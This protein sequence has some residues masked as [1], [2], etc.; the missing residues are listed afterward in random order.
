MGLC[1][2][3]VPYPQCRG[4]YYQVKQF[5]GSVWG[6]LHRDYSQSGML[7]TLSQF[8]LFLLSHPLPK[9]FNSISEGR[10]HCTRGQPHQHTPP[11]SWRLLCCSRVQSNPPC[12]AQPS[13]TSLGWMHPSKVPNRS[14]AVSAHSHQ[15]STV[16]QWH[17]PKLLLRLWLRQRFYLRATI[18]DLL[19]ATTSA[20]TLLWVGWTPTP[21]PAFRPD[22]WNERGFVNK[23]RT[24]TSPV[25]LHN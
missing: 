13:K 4:A 23:V 18:L 15:I 25:L 22:P 6:T 14:L 17:H 12:W 20:A 8:L 11:F 21:P 7:K 19:R 24:Q 16:W 5:P 1:N 9:P 10:C 3:T 2:Q